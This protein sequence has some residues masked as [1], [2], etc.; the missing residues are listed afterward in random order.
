M[1]VSEVEAPK[2]QAPILVYL[3]HSAVNRLQKGLRPEFLEQLRRPLFQ[4]VFSDENLSEISKSLGHENEFLSFFAALYAQHLKFIL[5]EQFLCTDR[6]SVSTIPPTSAYAEFIQNR[7]ESSPLGYGMVGTLK[8]LW[9][10]HSDKS[11]GQLLEQDRQELIEVFRAMIDELT[12]DGTVSRAEIESIRRQFPS[13]EQEISGLFDT[14]AHQFDSPDT[15]VSVKAIDAA[16]ATGGPKVLNNIQGPG[17]VR[18]IWDLISHQFPEG[19][20]TCDEHF[21]AIRPRWLAADQP[22]TRLQQVNHAYHQ[23][24]FAGYMRDKDM[25]ERFDSH[26]NDLTH[27]GMASFCQLFVT[28]DQR[29]ALKAAATY[30]FLSI[31]TMVYYMKDAGAK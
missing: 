15:P 1:V 14:L 20:M 9:G 31:P 10:G 12:T 16:L 11:Y 25:D 5:N 22:W 4:V 21:G 26:F 27:V 7:S 17:V 6:T 30:E 23:L 18:K 29:Q 28:A 13:A 2:I 3:D 8:K 19:T 24:N